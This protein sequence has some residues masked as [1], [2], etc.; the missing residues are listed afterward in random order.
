MVD[1]K[2]M[3]VEEWE[4]RYEPI[5]NED[6][7]EVF[8]EGTHSETYE[9]DFTALINAATELAGGNEDDAFKYIWSRLD[10]EDND[11]MYIENGIRVVNRLDYCLT[12][13]PWMSRED[14][15]SKIIQ[16]LYFE[17]EGEETWV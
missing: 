16:V 3:T 6:G 2:E 7:A 9:Y 5:Q 1:F 11:N 12:K 4:D 8:Y 10:G 13:R 15:K 17:S 14:D